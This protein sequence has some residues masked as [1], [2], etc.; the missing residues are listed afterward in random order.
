MGV[1]EENPKKSDVILFNSYPFREEFRFKQIYQLKKKPCLLIH[2]VDGP[3]SEIRNS[4]LK[5]D[6]L[7]FKFNRFLADGTIFQS[8][9]SKRENSELGMIK[10]HYETVISNSV[11]QKIF[12]KNGRINYDGNRKIRLITTS[13][14]SNWN[15]GFK[16]YQYLDE[17]L[18]FSKFE[19]TFIG[20]S[21]IVFKNINWIKPL[22]SED[23]AIQ[24]RRHDIFVIAS[25]NDPCSNSLI[26]A[27]HCGLPVVALN[28][29]GHP[30]I[31]GK[32]GMLFNDKNDIIE[33]IEETLQNYEYYQNNISLSNKT[34]DA[35][36]IKYYNFCI[37]IYNEFRKFNYKPK[38]SNYFKFLKLKYMIF[39]WKIEKNG[40]IK[41]LIQ[42]MKTKIK[43]FV[44]FYPS[45]APLGY[46]GIFNH[47][48]IESKS[49]ISIN[50]I[51]WIFDLKHQIPKFL[52]NLTGKKRKG[53][54][55]YS[56]SGDFF[57][58][59]IKW[60]LGNSVFFLKIIYTLNL[61]HKFQKEVND[62]INFILR[63]QKKDGSF[64]DPLIKTIAIT[65][66]ILKTLPKLCLFKLKYDSTK[67][68]ETRQTISAL[69]LFGISPKI[70]YKKIPDNEEKITNFLSK[71][72][73]ELPWGAGSHFSHLLFFLHHSNLNNKEELIQYTINW[74]NKIQHE[75]EG[76]WYK[77][78]PS[79]QQ[80]INGAMKIIT[81]LKVVKRVNFKYPE[82]MIDTLLSAMNDSQACDNFNIVYVLKYCNE[83]TG[84]KY[85]FSEIKDFLYDRLKIYRMHYHHKNGGFSFY[86]NK[87]NTTYYGAYISRGKNEPD[88]H[89]TTMFLWGISIIAQILNINNDLKFKE[90]IT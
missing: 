43:N 32:A 65:F 13:W 61:E 33:K 22:K 40:F 34:I 69:Y 28:D 63:F 86:Q 49:S 36:G 11:D 56:L 83:L 78:E 27:L 84:G 75:N 59:T 80:K 73:W 52:K 41:F 54:Y 12:N 88:I 2:R 3:I 57:G 4:D 39:K 76:F 58:E 24:L 48:Q 1:Y 44:K 9:W 50:D 26:E 77:G 47:C 74:V 42:S 79:I 23:L 45:S 81:G 35:V 55:H 5:I 87:S 89:G 72:N 51:N 7:I 30:E 85:R 29:G 70:K 46:S 60:G 37:E 71:L 68:A 67:R 14:S 90:F 15:K 21:P 38:K 17:N 16:I 6:K 10:N 19:M 18:D 31:I 64:Y 62:A 82:K 66:S 25:Q 8:N 53:F 20:N